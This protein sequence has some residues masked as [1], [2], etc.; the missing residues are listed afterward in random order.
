MRA[1]LEDSSKVVEP[2]R[3]LPVASKEDVIVA[4]GGSAGLMAAVAAARSGAKTLLIEQAGYLGGAT[5]AAMMAQV[6]AGAPGV[7]GLGR[8]LVDRL[9]A[10]GGVEGEFLIPIDPEAFKLAAM[11]MLRDAGATMLSY[12]M[13]TGVV[14]ENNRVRGVIVEN[15]SGRRAIL[16][17]VV[18]DATGDADVCSFAGAPLIMGRENDHKMRPMSMIF[19]MANVDIEGMIKYARENPGDFAPDPFYHILE[20]ERGLVR[21]VGYFKLVEQAKANGELFSDCYYIRLEGINVERGTV[22]VNA[23]RIY[24]VDGTNAQ[25]LSR[26]DVESRLQAFQLAAFLQKYAPGFGNAYLSQTAGYVGVR[27]TRHVIGDYVLTD[28]DVITDRS[29]E[30]SVVRSYK[31]QQPGQPSHSPDG[32]EGAPEDVSARSILAPVVG[33]NI[34]YRAMLP[35]DVDGLI[36]AGRCISQSHISDGFTRLQPTAWAMGQA[37]GTA[38]ALAVRSGVTPRALA[39]K[40]DEIRA[41]LRTQGMGLTDE[42][43]GKIPRYTPK[44]RAKTGDLA[45][46]AAG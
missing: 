30:D 33:F 25:D 38:A 15:K 44:E 19:Q 46:A 24:G 14:M 2:R 42:D 41:A 9:N 13:L 20:P 7:T 23:S 45:G 36:V 16:A 26:A 5:T 22:L 35:K 43:F 28:D 3:E 12:T 37:A 1:M 34:P 8:E 21:L 18:I 11:Q 40:V 4:G 17:D 10:M 29:F 32:R 39:G 27:E 31:R 6:S